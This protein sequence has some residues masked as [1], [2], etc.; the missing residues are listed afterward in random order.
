MFPVKKEKQGR[1][2]GVIVDFLLTVLLVI[3]IIPFF[4]SIFMCPVILEN[5]WQEEEP[6]LWPGS[7]ICMAVDK[8]K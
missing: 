7:L 6:M 8:A 1:W 4:V 3:P 5:V 2:Y